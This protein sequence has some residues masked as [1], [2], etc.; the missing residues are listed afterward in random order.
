MT[1]ICINNLEKVPNLFSQKNGGNWIRDESHYVQSVKKHHPKNTL[2]EDSIFLWRKK[3]AKD[4]EKRGTHIIDLRTFYIDLQTYTHRPTDL[5]VVTQIP[6]FI[7]HRMGGHG[8][9]NFPTWHDLSIMATLRE[10]PGL[11]V[12]L[13]VDY[14]SKIPLNSKGGKG[15]RLI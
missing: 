15:I 9:S 3:I 10:N 6:N 2:S 4:L 7:T 8:F 13:L 12:R 14:I 11:K 5:K 1:W